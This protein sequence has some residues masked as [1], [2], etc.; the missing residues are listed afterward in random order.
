VELYRLIFFK[1]PRTFW[2]FVILGATAGIANTLVFFYIN[3]LIA[4]VLGTT[5]VDRTVSFFILAFLVWFFIASRRLLSVL[6]I[7][8]TQNTLSELKKK[9][10]LRI[11]HAEYRLINN[12]RNKIHN[13]LNYDIAQ[14]VHAANMITD[15]ISSAIMFAGCLVYIAFLSF[16]LFWFSVLFIGVS[17][18]IYKIIMKNNI[19]KYD[20]LKGLDERFTSYLN[21]LL[22]GFKEIHVSR[23]IGQ[24]IVHGYVKPDQDTYNSIVVKTYMTFVNARYL[25]ITVFYIIVGIILLYGEQMFHVSKPELVNYVFALLFIN[26]PVQTVVSLLPVL[27]NAN[28]SAG[29]LTALDEE[30]ENNVGSD[31]VLAQEASEIKSFSEISI[32]EVCYQH[33]AEG[34][35]FSIGPISIAVRAS[36]VI[37]I[38]GGNGS[39]K[40]TFM[41][42]LLGLYQF[43]SGNIWLDGKKYNSIPT[44]LFSVVFS[45]FFLFERFYGLR[46]FDPEKAAFLIGLFELNDKV[47]IDKSGYS[48]INLSTGQRKRLAIIQ[49][50][51]D[52]K[53]ILVLDEWAADQDAGFRKK[54]YTQIIPYLKSQ[55]KTIIAITHDEKYFYLAD[56]LLKME[57]GKLVADEALIELK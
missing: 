29:R 9:F 14:V 57:F 50:L 17:T 22:S 36:E 44:E 54:F 30:L 38:S 11:I 47:T 26:N 27:A 7:S 19:L 23:A 15:M 42:C 8:F 40:T 28:V 3:R 2:L 51:M 53:P 12:S 52:E 1:S 37:F 13:V 32:E 4:T 33:V 21:E 24:D 56:R 20:T 48:T 46:S 45:D 41:K 6:T 39:G 49:V 43:Q 35:L 34:D 18:L 31:I 5:Q 25:G 55:G 10:L 16:K